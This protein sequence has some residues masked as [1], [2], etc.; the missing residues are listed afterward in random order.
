MAFMRKAATPLLVSV[1]LIIPGLL[2][3]G[4]ALSG[5]AQWS[6]DGLFYQARVYEFRGAGQASALTR[7]FQGP[8]GAELRTVDPER[9]GDPSWVAYNAQFYERRV[10]VP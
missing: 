6:P 9:S 5:P 3:V 10:A 7:A 4:G 2:A 8:L 1:A